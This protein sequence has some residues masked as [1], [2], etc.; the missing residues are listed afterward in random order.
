MAHLF[1]KD[2]TET[3]ADSHNYPTW[4]T[5]TKIMLTAKGFIASINEPNPQAHFSDTTK[6]TTLFLET[7]YAPRSQERCKRIHV[8]FELHS[9]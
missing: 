8:N 3:T 5:D 6:Y 7:S 9:K 1:N 4:A 2:F